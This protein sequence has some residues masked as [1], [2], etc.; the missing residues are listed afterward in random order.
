VGFRNCRHLTGLDRSVADGAR[1]NPLLEILVERG[2]AHEKK[3]VEHLEK[4]GLKT[5][6]VE[7]LLKP[8]RLVFLLRRRM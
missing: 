8:D 4:A 3:F 2:S 5:V 1:A 7:W 6:R